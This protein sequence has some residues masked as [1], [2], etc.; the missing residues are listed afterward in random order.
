MST[1][2]PSPPPSEPETLIPS[3]DTMPEELAPVF[4]AIEDVKRASEEHNR[5][6]SKALTNLRDTVLEHYARTTKRVD[7]HAKAI[8]E[9]R[10]FVGM[11]EL[12]Q[13]ADGLL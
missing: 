3:D 2:D 12:E 8:R 5:T 7:A 10:S 11:P 4:D 1:T 9:I 6:I 13:P